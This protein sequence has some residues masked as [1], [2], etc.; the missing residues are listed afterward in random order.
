MGHKKNELFMRYFS[1]LFPL[2]GHTVPN[3]L[4]AADD[5]NS[6]AMLP[7]SPDHRSDQNRTEMNIPTLVVMALIFTPLFMGE[8]EIKII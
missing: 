7:Y 6:E 3:S 4:P 8:F 1:P 2:L 5:T